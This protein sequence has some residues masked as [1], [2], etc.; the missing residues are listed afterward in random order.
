MNANGNSNLNPSNFQ[1]PTF[2]GEQPTQQQQTVGP[3]GQ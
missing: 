1:A 2:N 3:Q